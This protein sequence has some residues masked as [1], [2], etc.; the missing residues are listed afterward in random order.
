MG[1]AVRAHDCKVLPEVHSVCY[2]DRLFD[3]QFGDRELEYAGC[4]STA[5]P[6]TPSAHPES[7]H[8]LQKCEAR[9]HDFFGEDSSRRAQRIALPVLDG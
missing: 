2:R 1:K 5:R 3:L 9:L 7:L 8:T 6:R 4:R